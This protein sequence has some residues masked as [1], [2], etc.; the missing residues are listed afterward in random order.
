MHPPHIGIDITNYWNECKIFNEENELISLWLYIRYDIIYKYIYSCAFSIQ[1]YLWKII[2]IFLS[3]LTWQ[4]C[5]KLLDIFEKNNYNAITHIINVT[6]IITLITRVQ[7]YILSEIPHSSVYPRI[8]KRGGIY[9]RARAKQPLSH[10]CAVH[11]LPIYRERE[12]ARI[13][14]WEV[15]F[16]RARK[17]YSQIWVDNVAHTESVIIPGP[18][19]SLALTK[20]N[21]DDDNVSD[22]KSHSSII[23]SLAR[24]TRS[25]YIPPFALRCLLSN[26][27]LGHC[28]GPIEHRRRAV[29]IPIETCAARGPRLPTSPPRN[30]V[31]HACAR[32]TDF[33]SRK[34]AITRY[35]L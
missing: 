28:T 2:D 15:K 5:I 8:E 24:I 30:P 27:L 10:S 9:I 32:E 21:D 29:Y 35:Q 18:L 4:E 14:P 20:E 16:A 25:W 11:S 31:A 26:E 33:S 7:H 17:F 3:H 13:S 19:E 6:Q 12:R 23:N 34:V 22:E 1:I